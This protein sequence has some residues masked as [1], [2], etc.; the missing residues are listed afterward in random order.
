[1]ITNILLIIRQ[2]VNMKQTFITAIYFLLSISVFGQ[3]K[4]N[5]SS[6]YFGFTYTCEFM[7]SDFDTEKSVWTYMYGDEINDVVIIIDVKIKPSDFP[8]KDFID[9]IVGEQGNLK[10][11]AGYFCGCYAS[12]STGKEADGGIWKSATFNKIK[13]MYKITTLSYSNESVQKAYNQIE[14][15]FMFKTN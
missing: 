11:T 7:N 3:T 1:M 9:G 6:P 4:I 2:I 12:I 13:R 14:K 15:S 8:T 5:Q 10:I